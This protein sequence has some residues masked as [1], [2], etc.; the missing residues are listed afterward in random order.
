MEKSWGYCKM[1]TETQR[2]KDQLQ[3]FRTSENSWLQGTLIEKSP[4]KSLHTYTETKFHQ[5][6]LETKLHQLKPSS[7]P[8][9]SSTRRTT[10]IL[11]K[12]RNTTLNIKRWAARNHTKP[13]DTSK[14]TTGYFIALQR[15]EIQLHPPEHR[16]KFPQPGNLNKSLVQT[17]PQGADSTIKR[18]YDLLACRKGTPNTAI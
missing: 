16:H 14:F 6:K 5:L 12:N 15:E 9:S 3:N 7:K 8:K 18:N 2:Q 13:I 11:Q 10:L 17:H 1:I 4:P